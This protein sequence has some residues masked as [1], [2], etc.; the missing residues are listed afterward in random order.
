MTRAI[1]V[2]DSGPAMAHL[3]TALG[4]L[5][6][7]EIVR[8]ASG[9]APVAALVAR[10]APELV[11]VEDMAGPG[12]TDARLAEV[13][14]AAPGTTVVVL[15]PRADADW[16]SA[17]AA[18]TVQAGA[19]V[20]TLGRLLRDTVAGRRPACPAGAQALAA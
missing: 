18:A 17:G 5:D 19:D 7:L 9:R 11:L 10:F 12:L 6:W 16:L 8:F 1:V 14:R 15:G 3:T 20:E 2:A 4:A 13:L